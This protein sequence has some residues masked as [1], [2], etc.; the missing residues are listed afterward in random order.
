MEGKEGWK[1]VRK[2]I[3]VV[4]GR[5]VRKIRREENGQIQK[6]SKEDIDFTKTFLGEERETYKMSRVFNPFVL[7][8]FY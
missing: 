1:E 6:K 7:H 5:K 2:G 3:H 4:K 8:Y